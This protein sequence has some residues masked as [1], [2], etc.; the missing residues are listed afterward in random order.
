[1]TGSGQDVTAPDKAQGPDL[2]FRA[3]AGPF[4]VVLVPLLLGLWGISLHLGLTDRDAALT[5]LQAAE[6]L[7]VGLGASALSAELDSVVGDL[8]YIAGGTRL[9]EYLDEPGPEFRSELEQDFAILLWTKGV[10][11]QI[12]LLWPDGKE[13]VRVNRGEA[14]ARIV[15]DSQLQDKAGRYY[16][17]DTWALS[18]GD[19]FLSPFDLNVEQGRV[20]EPWKPMIRLGTP[21]I[22]S[23]GIKVAMVLLNVLGAPLLQ[24]LEQVTSQA[25]GTVYL[26]NKDGYPLAGPEP[27]ETFGF[28]FDRP[29]TSL[30][31]MFPEGWAAAQ[32]REPG[33]VGTAEGLWTWRHISPL[34][35]TSGEPLAQTWTVISHVPAA[36]LSALTWEAARGAVI[37][38]VAGTLFLVTISWLV[39]RSRAL[40]QNYSKQLELD[41]DLRTAE[42]S[43]AKRA[44]EAANAQKSIFLA[45]ISHDL[46]TPLNAIIGFSEM[47][48][49]KVYG[50]LGSD[51]YEDYAKDIYNSGKLLTNLIN[52]ILD[53]SKIE[54]GELELAK[55]PVEPT[56]LI[57]ESASEISAMPGAAERH[58]ILQ[59]PDPDINLITDGRVLIQVLNNLLSNAIKFTPEGGTI[60][61]SAF[62]SGAGG[63]DIWIEDTGIGMSEQELDDAVKPFRQVQNGLPQH[64]KGSGLGLYLCGNYLDKMNVGFKIESRPSTGTRIHLAFS[65]ALVQPKAVQSGEFAKAGE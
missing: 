16:V 39:A 4:F 61:V 10:Y 59:L 57:R 25:T 40:S 30:A 35:L 13:A 32:T 7:S 24:T 19:L 2:P 62:T 41:L 65:E 17:S 21:V 29:E 5:R 58:L 46:R 43:A 11:D 14:G 6:R 44:A 1:M 18:P 23:Q 63:Y 64:H 15:P 36:A 8:R 28:M 9:G 26:A 52:D 33:Q 55:D 12:R 38:S 49:M 54:A 3:F 45:S 27:S 37:L 48:V 60:T 50:K 47:M 20:E 22:N 56:A 34:P 51:R 53:I 31:Y 42:L